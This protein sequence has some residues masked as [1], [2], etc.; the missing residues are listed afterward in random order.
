MDTATKINLYCSIFVKKAAPPNPRN[1]NTKGPI[2][3]RDAAI[4]DITEPIEAKSVI[5]SFLSAIFVLL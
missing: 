2:Q 4:P 5:L 3:H 1:T